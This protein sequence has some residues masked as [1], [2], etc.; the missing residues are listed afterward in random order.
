MRNMAQSEA[1]A[2]VTFAAVTAVAGAVVGGV[3]GGVTAGPAGAVRGATMGGYLGGNIGSGIRGQV[4][5]ETFHPQYGTV[6]FH[7]TREQLGDDD[8]DSLSY[9][10]L[11]ERFGAPTPTAAS[12]S[13]IDQCPTYHL[14]PT[15]VERLPEGSRECT[16]CLEAFMTEQELRT[17][18]CL[19][20]FHRECIDHWLAQNGSC[21]ICK[22]V[23]RQAPGGS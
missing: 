13:T 1:F 2:A 14:Q 12:S 17:L 5:R 10:Q 3:I 20:M 19:H 9:E 16:I 15:D 18:P 23:L 6:V 7:G 22:T 4:Q 8:I 11:L 21:P